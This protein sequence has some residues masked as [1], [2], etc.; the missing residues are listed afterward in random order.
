MNQ[1]VLAA[2]VSTLLFGAVTVAG[3][4]EDAPKAEKPAA[5]KPAKGKAKGDKKGGDDTK[6]ARPIPPVT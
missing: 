4:A 5:E 6:A 2:L 1:K 3:A